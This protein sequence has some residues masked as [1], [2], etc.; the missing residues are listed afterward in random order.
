MKPRIYYDI[1]RPHGSEG[2]V[3]EQRQSGTMGPHGTSGSLLNRGALYNQGSFV[4]LQNQ[5]IHSYPLEPHG[6]DALRGYLCQRPDIV[7]GIK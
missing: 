3:M 5:G 4:T 2:L 1:A 6:T 7:D